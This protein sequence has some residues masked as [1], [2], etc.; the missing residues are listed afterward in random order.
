MPVHDDILAVIVSHDH[1]RG[2]PDLDGQGHRVWRLV[3][4]VDCDERPSVADIARRIDHHDLAIAH[5]FTGK[6]T[7]GQGVKRHTDAS[8]KRLSMAQSRKVHMVADARAR[9]DAIDR[10]ARLAV[11]V[12][13]LDDVALFQPRRLGPISL[14]RTRSVAAPLPKRATSPRPLVSSASIPDSMI[15]GAV[16]VASGRDGSGQSPPHADARSWAGGAPAPHETLSTAA[17][18]AAAISLMRLMLT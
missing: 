7:P 10:E 16:I 8:Q 18:E 17:A 1:A 4:G 11:P 3:I 9:I 2:H 14:L 5:V 6:G 15:S 12:E 13:R